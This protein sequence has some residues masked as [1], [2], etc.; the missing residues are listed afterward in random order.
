MTQ[1]KMCAT[2]IGGRPIQ[3]MVAPVAV[4]MAFDRAVYLIEIY[5]HLPDI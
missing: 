4:A 1:L 2:Q 5:Q 3:T